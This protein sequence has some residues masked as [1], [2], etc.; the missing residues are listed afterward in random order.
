MFD[1]MYKKLSNDD[2]E[3][4]R[5]DIAS[6]SKSPEILDTLSNDK[7]IMVLSKVANNP[8]TSAEALH[9]L[10]SSTIPIIRTYVA[11]NKNTPVQILHRL[12]KDKN[13]DVRRNVI[14]NKNITK[15]IL[16]SMKNSEYNDKHLEFLIH[17]KLSRVLFEGLNHK[18]SEKIID[19]FIEFARSYLQLS[20]TPDIKFITNSDTSFENKS[21]GGYSPTSKS[22]IITIS[23]RHILD[24]CR[25]LAHELVHYRQ[26]L[27][28]ELND[29]SGDD[30]SEHENEANSEAGIIMRKYAK[31]HPDLFKQLAID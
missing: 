2:D 8:Y 9:T 14:K 24:C 27:N 15:S 18:T 30:G 3:Y 10:S 23:N 31:L 28:G 22:I 17:E 25:S 20:S 1:N 21:F 11:K 16:N 4:V 6:T 5:I 26:D 29:N 19:D 12:S 7:S 13:P